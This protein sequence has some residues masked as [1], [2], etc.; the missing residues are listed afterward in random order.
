M[1][2]QASNYIRIRSQNK[3]PFQ[4][5]TRLKLLV[6]DSDTPFSR[7]LSDYLWE[8]GFESRV[9]GT[10]EKAKDLIEVWQPDILFLDSLLPD[11]NANS[12]LKFINTR[13]LRKVPRVILMSRSSSSQSFEEMQREGASF[14]LTKP[15]SLED[16]FRAVAQVYDHWKS[17]KQTSVK[18]PHG[19]TQ[20]PGTIKELHLVNLFLKQATKLEADE[21]NLYNLMRMINLKVHAVRCSTIQFLVGHRARVLASN[22]ND[23]IRDLRLDLRKYPELL[24]LQK[25]MAPVVIP[26]VQRS[27]LMAGVR[28]RVAQT[29]FET[30]IL[31]PIFRYGT[32]FGALSVRLQQ[33][34]PME[35]FYVEKFGQ[36]CSQIISLAIATPGQQLINDRM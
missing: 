20:S 13:S 27:D 22:D 8:N 10:V 19:L 32:L 25:T 5:K 17:N 1:K 7:R 36:I 6:A 33:C 15:F 11:T 16:A 28:S 4:T 26:N 12:M 18:T 14:H 23:Q 30:I 24:E 29:P 3:T 34:D 21:H 2:N 35:I 31:F 9:A